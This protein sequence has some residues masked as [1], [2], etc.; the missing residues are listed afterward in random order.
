MNR[1]AALAL[2][3]ELLTAHEVGNF[4]VSITK[5]DSPDIVTFS[6]VFCKLYESDLK[7]LI[8]VLAKHNE[9]SYTVTQGAIP[10]TVAMLIYDEPKEET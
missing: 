1:K 2:A 10:N 7:P 5:K 4:C 6:V 9:L 8:D 3:E